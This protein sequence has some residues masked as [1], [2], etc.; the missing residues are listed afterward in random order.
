MSA[1]A[2]AR[3]PA[4]PASEW[5]P[6]GAL[7]PQ[8]EAALVPAMG[9]AVRRLPGRHR[10]GRPPLPARGDEGGGRA[11]RAG[12]PGSRPRARTR[13]VPVQVVAPEDEREHM[14][15]AALARRQLSASQRAALALELADV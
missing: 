2:R 1:P 10:P 12:A 14:L 3:I 11:R 8:P 4:A 7:R 9:R 15:L 6:T 5:R 13:R